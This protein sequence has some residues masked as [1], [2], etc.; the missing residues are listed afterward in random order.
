VHYPIVVLKLQRY[1]VVHSRCNYLKLQVTFRARIFNRRKYAIKIT[2][3]FHRGAFKARKKRTLS[4][5]KKALRTG[6]QPSCYRR[7]PRF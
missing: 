4:K 1:D 5:N 7:A 6:K 3:P 2:L